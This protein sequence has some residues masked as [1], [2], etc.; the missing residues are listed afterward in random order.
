MDDWLS[1]LQS[2]IRRITGRRLPAVPVADLRR[3]EKL[4][5]GLESFHQSHLRLL[6]NP[7]RPAHLPGRQ[8]DWFERYD[9]LRGQLRRLLLDVLFQPADIYG[10]LRLLY[11][12]TPSVLGFLLPEFMSL[13][14]IPIGGVDP[15]PAP[16]S[17]HV[18]RCTQGFQALFS[19]TREDFQDIR[20]LHSL[21][22]REFGPLATGIV[23]LSENQL[24]ELE[25]IVVSLSA[26]KEL[27]RALTKSFV[28]QELGRL[29]GLRDKPGSAFNPADYGAAAAHFI[30]REGIA[31]RYGI[32]GREREY[33]LFLVRHHSLLHQ[34]VKGEV[35][36]SALP[37]I[38]AQGSLELFDAFFLSAFIALSAVR[39]G[40]ILEDLASWLLQIRALCHGV[41]TGHLAFDSHLEET[42]CQLGSLFFALEAFLQHGLPED[43]A[44]A[45]YLVSERWE[46]LD[47][48]ERLRAGKMIF[49]TERIFRLW[50]NHYVGFFD[51]ASLAVKVPLKFI[52]K[53]RRF[54]DIGYSSFEKE[55]F[56]ASRIYSTL[57]GL[58]EESRHFLLQQL[59]P[60]RVRILAFEKVRSYLNYENQIKLL[61]IGLLGAER[62]EPGRHPVYLSYLD[63][64]TR[65]KKRYEALNHFLNGLSVDHIW[66]NKPL[67]NH[68]FEARSGL[69]L[70]R[71]AFPGV[72]TVDFRDRINMARKV[73]HMGRIQDVN[74]LKNYFHNAL[75]S[76]KRYPFH[77]DDYEQ[78][79]ERAY[80][81]RL[82]EMTG[83][84]LAEAGQ[85]MNLA[86]TFR[87]LERL[88]TEFIERG[89]EVGFSADQLHRLNDLYELR[90]DRLRRGKALEIEQRL[91]ALE[92][93]PELDAYWA[94][95][96]AYLKE[97]R[98]FLG[99]EFEWSVARRFDEAGQRL[100]PAARPETGRRAR[101][102]APAQSEPSPK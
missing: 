88:N 16:A 40:L 92:H 67:L 7:A 37:E 97:N 80:E 62:T 20:F 9:E 33:L 35:S 27:F 41:L 26:N 3:L 49:A 50:G 65:I 32:T 94:Q 43:V 44:P 84:I 66:K 18:I 98:K 78:E 4:F 77:T 22:R 85:R 54:S 14:A 93:P 73:A 12:H 13:A 10:N 29:P 90:K 56:E 99:K 21:A 36:F 101:A 30:T 52:Y 51:L 95:M 76:L 28:F 8:Q 5:S 96:R 6:H 53:R 71:S 86:A 63:L 60:D 61:L 11:T 102:G 55:I 79:L 25:E 2:L 75:R 70:R 87:E 19:H 46:A 74:P 47:P 72:I 57:Q 17:E 48:T 24:E 83:R 69:S 38:L 81:D 82:G 100:D 64:S 42:Y 1:S 91:A 89:W 31:E 15:A 45:S 34:I 59:Y 23:G 68:L 39:E 58:P